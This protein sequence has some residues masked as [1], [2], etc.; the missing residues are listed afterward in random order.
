MDRDLLLRFVRGHGLLRFNLVLRDRGGFGDGCLRLDGARPGRL[1]AVLAAARSTARL[2]LRRCACRRRR[3]RIV[4]L[5]VLFFDVGPLG[6]ELL[7]VGLPGVDLP[8]LELGDLVVR[9]DRPRAL[10]RRRLPRRLLGLRFRRQRFGRL[11][12][13]G[14]CHRPAS[15]GA[16][17]A[18]PPHLLSRR[19]G[20]SARR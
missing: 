17:L 16:R 11:L 4:H 6:F 13:V 14:I 10:P 19:R 20:L 7:R 12:G 5:D 18:D 9:L 2:L 8:G 15:A 1:L 3:S